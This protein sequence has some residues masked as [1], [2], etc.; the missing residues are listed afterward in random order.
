MPTVVPTDSRPL[1]CPPIGALPRNR[2]ASSATGS[3]SPISPTTRFAVPLVTPSVGADAHIGPPYHHTSSHTVRRGRV[4]P[5]PLSLAQ[6]FIKMKYGGVSSPRRLFCTAPHENSLSLRGQCA[7]WPWQSVP[8]SPALHFSPSLIAQ[9]KNSGAYAPP[10][11]TIFSPPHSTPFSSKYARVWRIF[12]CI[13][14]RKASRE[15]NF[16]SPRSRLQNS[17]RMSCP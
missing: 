2:L 1:S 9:A 15:S 17:S 3:A 4:L 14:S 5:R 12:F 10:L 7:H 6:P 8:R 16:T 13:S 11:H